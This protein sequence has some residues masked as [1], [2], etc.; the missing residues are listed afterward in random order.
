MHTKSCNNIN[1]LDFESYIVRLDS[2]RKPYIGTYSIRLRW[3]TDQNRFQPH[4]TNVPPSHTYSLLE[5]VGIGIPRALDTILF[6]YRYGRN[7]IMNSRKFCY[8]FQTHEAT[9]T[10][11]QKVLAN[12]KMKHLACAR[13]YGVHACGCGEKLCR[14]HDASR[15][16]FGFGKGA[17]L[18][19][20]IMLRVCVRSINWTK[21]HS[22]QGFHFQLG[23]IRRNF[24]LPSKGENILNELD[25]MVLYRVIYTGIAVLEKHWA[26]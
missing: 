14:L 4:N 20:E 18:Y 22:A 9:R 8:D 5:T 19:D 15:T 17:G 11:W 12:F 26:M 3:Q 2:L 21:V 25:G 6:H 16:R 10:Y 1:E 24:V 13:D 23:T 7:G